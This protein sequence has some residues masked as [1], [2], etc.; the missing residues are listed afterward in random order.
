MTIIKN[1]MTKNF[2][3]TFLI[4]FFFSLTSFA[5]T[6]R[7]LTV[8]AE[9]NMVS[10]ITKIAHLYSQK[11]NVITSVTFNSS[12]DLI[13]NIDLGEPADVFISA[14]PGW[15]ENIRQKGLVDVYNIGYIARDEIALITS[16]SNPTLLGNLLSDELSLDDALK[17]L[18]QNKSTL[19]IDADGT[20]S[21]NFGEELIKNSSLNHLKIFKKL[22]EDKSPILSVIKS[23]DKQYALLLSSQVKNEKDFRIIATKKSLNISYQALVIAGNNMEVARE[24][25]KFLRSNTAK[26]IFKDS[27]FIID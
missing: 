20:S 11:A 2:L 4:L 3:T 12:A 21:G 17:T 5:K 14:H 26:N 23:N 6:S 22:P 25:L 13:A 19:I 16:R 27:G 8:F 7:N 15:I 18:N 10:A 9:P 24:F 1:K